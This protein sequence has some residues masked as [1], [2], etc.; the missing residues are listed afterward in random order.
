MVV[1]LLDAETYVDCKSKVN[2]SPYASETVTYKA[3]LSLLL[4]FSSVWLHYS[5]VFPMHGMF[6]FKYLGYFWQCL[7][8]DY[9]INQVGRNLRRSLA[10]SPA[11]S[12]VRCQVRP[13]CWGLYLIWSWKSPRMEMAKC[14]WATSAKCLSLWWITLFILALKLLFLPNLHPIFHSPFKTHF[15]EIG[16]IFL[17]NF[18]GIFLVLRLFFLFQI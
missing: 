14:L 3:L 8:Q 5:L 6:S 7:L 15:K 11:Q 2:M 4:C 12:K 9:Q 1:F 17:I 18:L 13:G 16:F 10:Q